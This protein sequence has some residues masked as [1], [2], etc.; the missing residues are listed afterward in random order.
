MKTVA[1]LVDDE[2][3]HARVSLGDKWPGGSYA[4]ALVKMIDAQNDVAIAVAA[5]RERWL[6]AAEAALEILDD[7][8]E[9]SNAAHACQLLRECVGPNAGSKL[10]TKAAP[11]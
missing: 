1:W 4:E 8:P 9:W 10:D 6:K 5:E 2:T 7:L 3:E 11:K